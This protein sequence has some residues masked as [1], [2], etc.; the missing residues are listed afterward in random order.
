M[1]TQSNSIDRQPENDI[2]SSF[3]IN[4]QNW[5]FEK[6]L[7][8]W[9]HNGYDWSQSM[10]HESLNLNGKPTTE[11]KRARVQG[12]QTYVYGLFADMGKN[13]HARVMV[14]AGISAIRNNYLNQH[15]LLATVLSNNGKPFDE[16]NKLY[17]QTFFLLA[18]AQGR[19]HIPNASAQAEK[20][21]QKIIETY[22]NPKGYGF[23][24]NCD[25]HPYQSNAHMHLLEASLAWAEA[26]RED[27]TCGAAWEKLASDICLLAAEKF[28]DRKGIFLREFFNSKWQP[29]E[30]KDGTIVEPGHQFEWAWLLARWARYSNNQHYLHLA[31][32]LFEAGIKGINPNTGAAVNTMNE[33]LEMVTEDARLWPQTEWLKAALILLELSSYEESQHYLNHV[34][35]SYKSLSR[36][37]ETEKEGLWYDQLLG[38]N[39]F[40]KHVSP[41]SSFYHIACAYKQLATTQEH[42]AIL[43]DTNDLTAVAA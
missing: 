11:N 33:N 15:G 6:A 27:G 2:L 9:A 35:Q 10:W 23:V 34:E 8:L 20:L 30:G 16:S 19:K 3:S 32:H 25:Q 17:D 26:C 14:H 13:V 12:R 28:I 38:D 39:T 21:R 22:K 4:A 24:E 18:L 29:K 5:L 36:Y 37:L 41:A 7:P 40:V 1:I 42:F 31:K 43:D